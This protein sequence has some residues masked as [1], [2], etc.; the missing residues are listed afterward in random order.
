VFICIYE[1]ITLY[2]WRTIEEY[3]DRQFAQYYKDESGINRKNIND[4][5]VHCCL[6]FVSPYG[7]GY[8]STSLNVYF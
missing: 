8:V 1:N 5:R 6:Y 4:T 2:S 7:H 3:I